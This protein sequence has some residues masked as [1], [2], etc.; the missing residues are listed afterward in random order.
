MLISIISLIVVTIKISLSTHTHTHTYTHTH[1]LTHSLSHTHTHCLY[2]LEELHLSNNDYTS[3]DLDPAFSHPSISTLHLNNST[4]SKWEEI[5]KLSSAFPDLNKLVAG[6]LPVTEIP[7]LDCEVFPSLCSLNL[8]DSSLGDWASIEHLAALPKLSDLSVLNFPLGAK[9]KEK[10]RRFA[11][12][13]RLPNLQW[14][15]K[16]SITETEREDAERWLIRQFLDVA[17]PPPIYHAL[18][19]KHGAV[20]RLVEVNLRP[21][22]TAEVEF[23]FQGTCEQK[24]INI[25]QTVKEFKLWLSEKIVGL[26]PSEFVVYYHD[27]GAPWGTDILRHESRA[28]HSYR[29]KDGDKIFVELKRSRR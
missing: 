7:E 6:S 13:G 25:A 19:A 27:V 23:H 21:K 12:I 17:S 4:I 22:V 2:S 11:V 20:A 1:T 15:N 3:V 24:T 10:E 16:S 5:T 18:V 9:F 29:I 26:P 28:L 14:L 8:N